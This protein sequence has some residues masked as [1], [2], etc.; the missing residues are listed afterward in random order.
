M[1]DTSSVLGKYY[2][3]KREMREVV[4]H[5]SEPTYTRE[6]I[7]RMM[8]ILDSTYAEVDIEQ[9]VDNASQLNAKERTVLL[10]LLEDFED[11][12]YGTL[13]NW[14]T[15]PVNLELKPDSKQFNSRYYPVP[16]INK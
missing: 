1:K 5:T 12:F 7:E 16:R 3:T 9:V 13:G 6:A 2:L 4:M 14:S 15:E 11:L 8:K 10:S